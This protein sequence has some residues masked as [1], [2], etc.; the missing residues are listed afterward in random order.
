[1]TDY[2]CRYCDEFI[3]QDD[4]KEEISSCLHTEV[5]TRTSMAVRYK[6]CPNCGYELF[7]RA[8]ECACGELKLEDDVLC[9]RCKKVAADTWSDAVDELAK[10]I[11]DR[12]DAKD[13]LTTYVEHYVF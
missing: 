2:Y 12:W 8:N 1:M 6:V 11:G 5:D 4:A 7:E 10:V 13:V 3:R 9:R